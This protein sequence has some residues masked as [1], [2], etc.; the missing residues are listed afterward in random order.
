MNC[1]YFQIKFS[2]NHRPTPYLVATLTNKFLSLNDRFHLL[3]YLLTSN[4][5]KFPIKIDTNIQIIPQTN[6]YN[7][8][9]LQR[10]Q[11]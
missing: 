2:Y 5:I 10:S 6:V 3:R 7:Y 8:G 9:V 1:Y 4:C 11:T